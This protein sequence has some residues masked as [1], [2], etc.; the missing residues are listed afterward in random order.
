MSLLL[1][2]L[3]RAEQE[4]L[5]KAGERAANDPP[6]AIAPA[7]SATRREPAN[8]SLE[9]QPLP[10]SAPAHA[11]AAAKPSG[12]ATAQAVFQAKA[13]AAP[14]SA[15]RK[16][17]LLWV[18]GAVILLI[19]L[20]IAGYIWYSVSALQP[21][22]TTLR[23]R[24]APTP[25]PAS[26]VTSGPRLETL[27][28]GANAPNTSSPSPAVESTATPATR[29]QPAA[30]TTSTVTTAPST[31]GSAP[32]AANGAA[33]RSE[34]PARGK[35]ELASR[36]VR[37]PQGAP[38]LRLTPAEP[39]RVPVAILAGYDALRAGDLPAARRG[40]TT[41]IAA[42]P[43]SVDAHLG[44]ATVE[45][46]VGNVSAAASHYRRVLDLDP[47]N[48]TALAG[49]ASMADLSQPES[50]EEQLRADLARYPQSAALHFALGN[51]YASRG[52]W[53]EAQS[54]FFESLRLQ[55]SSADTLYNLAVAM[56]HMKQAR[57]ASEYY[58]RALDAAKMQ[59]AQF[60]PAS[61][62]RRIS[63]LKP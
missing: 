7:P 2:A 13:A 5:A 24:P 26:G 47:R 29:T 10:G 50:V 16:A 48:A 14:P 22:I 40:Y 36:L 3:K 43:A 38:Q 21:R 51:L 9:L 37:E 11:G 41:A 19:A 33:P 15:S 17:T 59:A 20:G 25:P 8:N 6:P 18:G 46:R 54:A 53:E 27:V 39:P 60:D 62:A 63:E 28:P 31:S 45:A 23:P 35:A 4:K 52:R 42:E 49:L 58:A 56:D 1:D 61:V 30:S 12:A 55:P 32:P 34:D 44:L 57:L